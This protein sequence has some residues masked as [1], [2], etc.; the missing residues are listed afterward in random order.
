[1]TNQIDVD[2]KI[3]NFLK[4]EILNGFCG[5]L[6]LMLILTSIYIYID[7]IIFLITCLSLVFLLF[8]T[9]FY[10][11]IFKNP[12]YYIACLGMICITIF[13]TIYSLIIAIADV[14]LAL[15]SFRYL[16]IAGI[17]VEAFY[18]FFI[19]IEAR[20]NNYISYFHKRYGFSWSGSASL[21]Y[22]L[23]YSTNEFNKLDKGRQYWQ[24]HNLEEVKKLKEDLKAFNRRFKKRFLKIFESIIVISYI[25]L[26]GISLSV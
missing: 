14:T 19:I 7:N 12:F 21:L 22:R 13:P 16:I 5:I 6:E 10:T 15:D 23:Y 24:D 3:P 1:M 20:H 2:S 25:I 4:S 8:V 11:L 9:M 18:I 26:F 17:I